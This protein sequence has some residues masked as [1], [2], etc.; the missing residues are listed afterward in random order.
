[1]KTLKVMSIVGIVIAG[2]SYLCIVVFSNA[3]D[4][5]AASGWGIIAGAYLLA[6]SIVVLVKNKKWKE[7]T[8]PKDKIN[9]L[10]NKLSSI[11]RSN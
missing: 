11:D 8:K 2:L 6:F 9:N 3:V 1:M 4:Y 7:Q 5:E 10:K